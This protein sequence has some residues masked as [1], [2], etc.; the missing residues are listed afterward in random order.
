M[1]AEGVCSVDKSNKETLKW[2]SE[3][4]EGQRI[5]I[6][7]LCIENIIIAASAVG[8]ALM[9]KFLIDYATQRQ[10]SKIIIC[11]IVLIFIMLAQFIFRIHA[12]ISREK[13]KARIGILMKQNILNGILVKEYSQVEK[14]HSGEILNRMFSDVSVVSENVM[15][16]IT[17]VVNSVSRIIL[18][19]IVLLLI[20]WKFSLILIVSAL[21]FFYI[22]KTLRNRL[23]FIHKEA[24][25]KEDKVRSYLQEL[26][27]NL[28]ILK[29][30]GVKDEVIKQSLDYQ[31]DQYISLMK[32][33]R[34]GVL[35]GTVFSFVFQIGYIYG[36]IWGAMGILAGSMT[37]GT[38]LVIL[39]LVGQ[40]QS[41]IAGLSGVVPMLY[42]MIASAERII[43][44][45]NIDENDIKSN[46]TNIKENRDRLILKSIFLHHVSYSYGTN[47]V[48]QEVDITIHQSD[49]VA[50][51]GSSGCGKSTLLLL[52]MG[53]YKPDTGEVCVLY[54]KQNSLEVESCD[55][56]ETGQGLFSYVPQK[57]C[58]FTGT[59]RE[60]V[61]F[62]KSDVTDADIWNALKIACADDFVSAFTNELDTEIRENGN[63]LS[64]GQAQR[65]AIARAILCNS[66]VLILDE[67]T[68]AL[69]EDT[70][71]K[72]LKNISQIN[73]LTCVIVTHRQAA[74][75]ICNKQ[76]IVK[77]NVVYEGKYESNN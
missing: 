32:Q 69:D 74:F 9:C 35:S 15:N 56:I 28:L 23:K 17:G 67:A 7:L 36:L 50:V 53:I 39:Q 46:H 10:V 25:G 13:I 49:M 59:I 70:E 77:D 41:P 1:E 62:Y 29:V 21:L 75:R 45:E 6:L 24:Q 19:S 5:S 31:E 4:L 22:I 52:L 42:S 76:F 63:G 8:F 58:L 72:L 43:A 27:E 40:I 71:I 2:I 37:Y 68:S 60:N 12:N 61:A 38:M 51:T 33:K 20:D 55:S 14:F 44:I 57:N 54:E 66:S 73:H 48:L 3:K 47:I 11:C 34:L 18:A 64:Q 26:V 65:I 16:I 30:F